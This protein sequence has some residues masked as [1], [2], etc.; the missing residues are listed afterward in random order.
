MRFRE[1]QCSETNVATTKFDN[2]QIYRPNLFACEQLISRHLATITIHV[3]IQPL[4][5]IFFNGECLSFSTLSASSSS[6]SLR[7]NM[8][9]SLLRALRGSRHGDRFESDVMHDLWYLCCENVQ[10]RLELSVCLCGVL[11]TVQ[12]LRFLS[13]LHC[14][15][16]NWRRTDNNTIAMSDLTHTSLSVSG[17]VLISVAQLKT[18]TAKA[19]HVECRI[20]MLP[21]AQNSGSCEVTFPQRSRSAKQRLRMLK[22]S[23]PKPH[24]MSSKLQHLKR[25]VRKQHRAKYGKRCVVKIDEDEYDEYRAL[26]RAYLRNN[27]E[28]GPNDIVLQFASSGAKLIPQSDVIEVYTIE[29]HPRNPELNGQKGLRAKMLI[30]T[31]TIIGEYFGRELLMNEFDDVYGG[32]KEWLDINQYAQ[33]ST[34]TLHI[35]ASQLKFFTNIEC[36]QY[37]NEGV[38]VDDDDDDEELEQQFGVVVDGKNSDSPHQSILIYMNDCRKRITMTNVSNNDSDLQNVH[39]LQVVHNGWPKVL[40]VA[41]KDIPIGHD[42]VTFYGRHQV[43]W[44]QDLHRFERNQRN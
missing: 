32:S 1:T 5:L 41:I 25:M 30:P 37:E 42:I 43:C 2:N 36:A 33:E 39:F 40:V 27:R 31:D 9:E 26:S 13:H 18:Y 15:E 7:W 24:R 29:R 4:R 23:P 21:V 3:E 11:G 6:L 44:L 16:L 35:K 38:D 12:R 22:G 34:L 17:A 8:D 28:R 19:L 14:K 20:K 10:G